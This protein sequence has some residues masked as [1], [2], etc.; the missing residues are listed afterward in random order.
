MDNN[1]LSEQLAYNGDT[2][3]VT[4]VHRID[5]NATTI[6]DAT[7]NIINTFHPRSKSTRLNS[8]HFTTSR[9]PS[10]A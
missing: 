7:G 9:M 8:S 3:T 1:L 4:H 10:S 2:R 6:E 5:Y